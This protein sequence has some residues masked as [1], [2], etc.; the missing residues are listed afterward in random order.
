M[1][2]NKNKRN[3]YNNHRHTFKR[4][5]HA[6]KYQKRACMHAKA[7]GKIDGSRI[8]NIEKLQ[9]YIS[10]L[11]VHAAKCSG[12][13]LLVGEKRD[14]LASILSTR[15][16]QCDHSI[17]LQ[18]S[19]KVRGPRGYC[20]WECNLAAVWGQMSTGGGHSKLQET[21]GV[22]GVPVMHA[23]H[24]INTERD[25]GEWW[26]KELQEVMAEAGK[27]E[28]RLAK[29][30]GDYHEGVPAITVIVDG[31]WSK[32]SHRHSY[33]AKSGVG[34]IVG[35]TTGKLLYI[36]VRNKYCTACTQGVPPDQHTCYKN[37]DMSSSKMEADIILEGF[38]KAEQVHGV[39]YKRFVGDGDS[40]VYPTLIDNVPGWG[41][42]IEKLECA[43]HACK[44]YRSGLEKLVQDKPVYKGR[45][46]LTQKMR[47]RLT[48]AARCAIKMRS[49]EPDN[50]K[51]V[52]LLERDL[53]NGPYH[54][55]GHHERCSP[56][57]CLSAKERVES[58]RDT[59]GNGAASDGDT[60]YLDES[61]DLVC[62]FSYSEIEKNKYE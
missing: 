27:E 21:M 39:R 12:D 6:K 46:G 18:T 44:C 28:K 40:S 17:V 19:R 33:N 13:L 52:K 26:Q 30:R 53:Q 57:F 11:T 38:K 24:F 1:G 54:C 31:G 15:C 16:T 20:R 23:R 59:S 37:W 51:A 10:S 41:R 34:I 50:T 45:G 56:D 60:D 7:S 25:I 3:H 47:C 8:I 55:F 42:Y 36:G 62:K 61:N 32:R 4:R 43:N 58:S 22:L 29:E 5:W 48:S 2:S 9:E 49:K 35:Q 14:G